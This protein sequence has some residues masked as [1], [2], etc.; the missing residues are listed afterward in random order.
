MLP[1]FA[2]QINK[3]QNDSDESDEEYEIIEYDL[4]RYDSKDLAPSNLN[5][6]LPGN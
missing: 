1:Q 3:I 5:F 6:V 2:N 4:V